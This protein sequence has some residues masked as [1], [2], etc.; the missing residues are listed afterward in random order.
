MTNNRRENPVKFTP[1]PGEIYANA[2]GGRYRCESILRTGD[3]AWMQNVAS[4]WTCRCIGIVRYADGTIEWNWSKDGYFA[5]NWSKDGYFA[6][7]T[8]P[9]VVETLRRQCSMLNAMLCCMI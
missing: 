3:G 9:A 2:G 7:A 8:E 1:V 6:K 5:W 4:G